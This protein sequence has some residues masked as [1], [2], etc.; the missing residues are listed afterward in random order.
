[1]AREPRQAS[2]FRPLL[3]SIQRMNRGRRPSLQ[4][5]LSALLVV[6]TVVAMVLGFFQLLLIGLNHLFSP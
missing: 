6:V 4:F 1:M 2:N 5:S 3:E